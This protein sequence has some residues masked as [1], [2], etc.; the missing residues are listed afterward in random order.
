MKRA[1]RRARQLF[2]RHRIVSSALAPV[3][4]TSALSRR[5]A[6]SEISA[7]QWARVVRDLRS[8]RAHWE[9]L[10]VTDAIL[11]RAEEVVRVTRL[12]SLDAVH[13]ASAQLSSTL[14]GVTL[15]FVTADARQRDAAVQLGLE[16]VWVD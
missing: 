13:V 16:V 15:P 2:R 3:E 1:L 12:R 4:L 10:A 6:A 7:V 11:T 8:D 14:V 9:L 5:R